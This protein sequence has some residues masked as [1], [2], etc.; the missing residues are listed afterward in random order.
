MNLFYLSNTQMY[1]AVSV[2]SSSNS[3][4]LTKVDPIKPIRR[5]YTLV[6]T[7]KYKNKKIK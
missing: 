5:M 1:P 3:S 2:V 7:E 4:V 6:D